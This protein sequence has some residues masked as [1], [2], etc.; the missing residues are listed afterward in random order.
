VGIVPCHGWRSEIKI[1]QRLRISTVIAPPPGRQGGS[2]LEPKPP[3]LPANLG[4]RI[5]VQGGLV[6][7][8]L[9]SGVL[10]IPLAHLCSET[11]AGNVGGRATLPA[12]L[13]RLGAPQEALVVMDVGIAT[14]ANRT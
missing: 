5:L 8:R 6:Y 12:M 9:L 7:G 3:P 4:L 14:E 11:F 13:N 10:A 2:G 1:S